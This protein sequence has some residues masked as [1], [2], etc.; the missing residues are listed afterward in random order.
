VVWERCRVCH[1]S[2]VLK[3]VS[4]NNVLV[5]YL[6]VEGSFG[7]Y[8]LCSILVVA[9]LD[10]FIHKISLNTSNSVTTSIERREHLLEK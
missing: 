10:G 5:I 7:R 4:R 8:S 2:S 6:E 1:T 9:D 3:V